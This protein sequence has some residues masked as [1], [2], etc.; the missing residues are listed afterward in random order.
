MEPNLE[1]HAQPH[2]DP[3]I[4]RIGFGLTHPYVEQC[5]GA[6]L[7]P[8]GIAILRRMPVLWTDQEPAH[9]PSAELG[10]SLGL[11]EHTGDQSRFGRALSR[12]ARFRLGEWLEHGSVLSIYTEVA[13][14][15][16]H[17]LRHVPNWTR[18]THDHLLDRHLKEVAGRQNPGGTVADIT[19][20]LD[21]LQQTRANQLNSNQAL[22][23]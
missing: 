1:I 21:L 11:T 2:P 17:Q 6:L 23:R 12:L 15:T 19:A 14:L 22:G 5:W 18:S 4:H 13:P 20:R 10:A 8:S 3:R 7:G 16:E 9:V